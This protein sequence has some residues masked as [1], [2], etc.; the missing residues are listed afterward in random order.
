ML[1]FTFLY[2]YIPYEFLEP[3]QREDAL[4]IFPVIVM[5]IAIKTLILRILKEH[6]E[7]KVVKISEK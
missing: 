3:N 2:I 1:V 7:K 5:K 4:K 6:L